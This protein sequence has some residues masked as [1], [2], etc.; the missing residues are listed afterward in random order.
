MGFFGRRWI[1]FRRHR[2]GWKNPRLYDPSPH[3]EV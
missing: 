2:F 3:Q 1:R